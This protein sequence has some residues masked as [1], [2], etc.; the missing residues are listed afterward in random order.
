ML[1]SGFAYGLLLTVVM[2]LQVRK[3]KSAV[4]LLA[5]Q[6]VLLAVLTTIA[7]VKTGAMP[8]LI[9]AFLTLVVK[10]AII[11]SILHYTINKIDIKREVERFIGKQLSLICAVTLIVIGYRVTSQL[12]LPGD[13]AVHE[14]LPIS[15]SLILLGS[16]MM[17]VHKKALMQ[18]I[19]LITIE[20]GMFLVAIS[21]FSGMPFI[22][23]LAGF[24][25]LLIMVIVIGI[26]TE[27]IH[28][29]FDSISTD[30]LKD[31]KG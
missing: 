8:M 1:E 20:N 2:I 28:S 16:F 12:T 27:R 9:T 30:Q 17:V 5:A 6:S 21:L 25:E 31:L 29:T 19:G 3:V 7:A 18:G 22:V 10:A 13:E 24:L 4:K 14:F 26:L 23:E 15:I 11:P